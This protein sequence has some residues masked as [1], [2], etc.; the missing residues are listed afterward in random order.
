MVL[1]MNH[2]HLKFP[3]IHKCVNTFE[4]W[5]QL[6]LFKC[7]LNGTKL[8][9]KQ[10]V[11][12]TTNQKDSGKTVGLTLG[13]HWRKNARGHQTALI[14]VTSKLLQETLV[15]KL[16]ILSYNY[17]GSHS[18]KQVLI[19]N[20][21]LFLNTIKTQNVMNV[22][23]RTKQRWKLFILYRWTRR[24]LQFKFFGVKNNAYMK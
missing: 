6:F 16:S 8:Y 1:K 21:I 13:I 14:I 7:H 22:G 2:C 9:T 15:I 10:Q 24:Q 18:K 3:L 12:N 11:R 20:N 23:D 5:C 19:S 4:C 17:E